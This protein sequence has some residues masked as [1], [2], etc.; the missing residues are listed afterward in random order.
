MLYMDGIVTCIVMQ[1]IVHFFTKN[2][3]TLIYYVYYY[4]I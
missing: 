3:Y 2:Y 1:T 4:F